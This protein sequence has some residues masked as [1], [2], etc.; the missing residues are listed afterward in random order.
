MNM[1]LPQK[2]AQ[3]KTPDTKAGRFAIL[4]GFTGLQGSHR[5]QHSYR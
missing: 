3:T 5:N 2:A 4:S 1:D